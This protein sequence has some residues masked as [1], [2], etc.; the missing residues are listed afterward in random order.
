MSRK[1]KGWRNEPTR[2]ALARKGIKT[3]NNKYKARGKGVDVYADKILDIIDEKGSLVLPIE[4]TYED[5]SPEELKDLEPQF[6]VEE[7]QDV[8]EDM[9]SY[10]SNK[11]NIPEDIPVTAVVDPM[12]GTRAIYVDE[13]FLGID[14]EID[15]KII[16][17]FFKHLPKD[18]AFDKLKYLLIHEMT[19]LMVDREI[20]DYSD[21]PKEFQDEYKDEYV[22]EMWCENVADKYTK[23]SVEVLWSLGMAYNIGGVEELKKQYNKLFGDDKND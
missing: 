14:I 16:D 1:N 12:G 8:L 17:D 22:E 9:A 4:E 7:F 19:H 2:H 21:I 11:F 6:G 18:V 15:T 13:E 10:Y 23:Y 20:G 5:A 3:T